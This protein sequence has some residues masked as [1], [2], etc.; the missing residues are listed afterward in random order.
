MLLLSGW[1]ESY[2]KHLRITLSNQVIIVNI[3]LG[4]PA[5]IL[6]I[7][8][9]DKKIENFPAGQAQALLPLSRDDRRHTSA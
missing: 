1:D 8:Q 3:I 4:L 9:G 6:Q 2:P 7:A 5:T